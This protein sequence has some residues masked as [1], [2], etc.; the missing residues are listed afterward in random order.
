[1]P[2]ASLLLLGLALAAP[3]FGQTPDPGRQAFEVRCARC[4]GAD[5]NGGEMGPS[6]VQR[7]STQ[8]DAQLGTLI[9]DGLPARGM[10]PTPTT[11]TELGALLKFLRAIQRAPVQDQGPR[12]SFQTIDGAAIEGRVIGQ[13]VDDIQ[14][15]T[16]D[17]RVRLLRQTGQRVREVTSAT[18]GPPTTAIPAAT[19]TRR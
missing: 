5:G 1:M 6:I 13:G 12:R 4:H 18:S 10:P 2:R 14:L 11:E 7:L 16:D 3:A 15:R 17:G 8:T 19:A 9:R